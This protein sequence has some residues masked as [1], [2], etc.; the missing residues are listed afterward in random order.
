MPY[1]QNLSTINQLS[2]RVILIVF[3]LII[4]LTLFLLWYLWRKEEQ[5]VRESNEAK[6]K[7]RETNEK[8]NMALRS[9]EIG[10]WS[11]DIVN[12]QM[13]LDSST[14][15]LLGASMQSQIK[16]LKDFVSCLYPEDRDVTLRNI[17]QALEQGTVYQAE[18]RVIHSDNSMHFLQARGQIYRAADG[19]PQT[20]IGVCWDATEINLQKKFLEAQS[21]INKVMNASNNFKEILPLML[22]AICQCL[23]WDMACIWLLDESSTHL[24]FQAI[25][26]KPT[27][28]VKNFEAASR[29]I[30]LTK[31]EVFLGYI[32]GYHQTVWIKDVTIFPGFKRFKE[33]QEIGLKGAIGFPILQDNQLIGVIECF[34]RIPLP[35]EEDLRFVNLLAIL[36]RDI[37]QFIQSIKAE[38]AR[39]QLL[40]IIEFTKDAVISTNPEGM[41]K[42]WNKGSEELFGYAAEEVIDKSSKILFPSDKED[43]LKLIL[44]R[45]KKGESIDNYETTRKRK[46]GSIVPV[47]ITASP[48]KDKSNQIVGACDLIQDLSSIKNTIETLRKSEEQFR[49]FVETTG[50]W[51]WAIDE[52]RKLTYSNPSIQFILGYTTE[53]I[54]GTDLMLLIYEEDREQFEKDFNHFTFK[55]KGWI[56][57]TKRWLHKNGGYRWLES[58]AEPILNDKNQLIGYRGA[59]RDVTDR[60]NMEQMKNEFVSMVSH[61]MRTPLTAIQGSLGLI[62]GKNSQDLNERTNRLLNIA[63]NNCLR[64]AYIINDIL[65]VQRIEVGKLEL[66][67]QPISLKDFI[68]EVILINQPFAERFNV[69]VNADQFELEKDVKVYADYNRLMQ[70]MS[71]LLSNAIKHSPESGRVNIQVTL[72]GISVCISV[73]DH[74]EGVPENFQDKVFQKFAQ[75]DPSKRKLSGT[76]LGLYISKHIVEKLGGKINFKSQK[77]SETVFYFNLPLWNETI[78]LL[79]ANIQNKERPIL[80]YSTD[81]AFCSNL[82]EQLDNY[83]FRHKAS[84]QF[85]ELFGVLKNNHPLAF[86][87][88]LDSLPEESLTTY[89]QQ[90]I[91]YAYKILFVFATNQ[92]K[93]MKSVFDGQGLPY[94]PYWLDKE[95]TSLESF[96]QQLQEL[97]F[98]S[99]PKILFLENNK[100]VREIIS[101][102]L[103]EDFALA[104]I[105]S[106]EEA[107]QKLFSHH[108]QAVLAENFLCGPFFFDFYPKKLISL[109]LLAPGETERK[110]IKNT[111]F[112]NKATLTNEKLLLL[113]KSLIA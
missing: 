40:A 80:L 10:T 78:P 62:I 83:S 19:T 87:I 31:G 89:L 11:W 56:G 77:E 93:S 37:G 48:I 106:Y 59:D 54:L 88:D 15:A 72:Q 91:P 33:A 99:K 109:I 43:E 46:D 97:T 28:D 26:Y 73:I 29:R 22:Q 64:L 69:T 57:Q 47:L 105:S 68:K 110:G 63:H 38:E 85:E 107:R 2:N 3:L 96:V 55:K 30:P 61:E 60:K 95:N 9:G 53:E 14:K 27:I 34:R 8:L 67:L 76:G 94:I 49:V 75:A 13:T 18:Y 24:Q 82:T 52:H 103:K 92:M 35:Q 7:L 86:I 32:W 70:V 58:N 51:V 84:E 39:S 71:N 113:L 5:R 1:A 66:H 44:N 100:E 41:I 50:E 36:G 101:S 108:F 20:A 111:V 81:A 16:T 98:S 12:D 6:E 112:L 4:F 74:G 17:E 23:D 79:Q 65:D 45:I 42:T 104:Y 90:L 25:W 102:I 21:L